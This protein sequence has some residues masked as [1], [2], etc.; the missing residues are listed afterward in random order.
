VPVL[1]F[2]GFLAVYLL[3][4]PGR[5]SSTDPWTRYA[6][7]VGLVEYGRPALPAPL[8][9]GAHWVV[10]G[11]DGAAYSYFGIGQSLVFAP[12]YWLGRS[13]RDLTGNEASDWPAVVA[14]FANTLV[15]AALAVAV[16]G[17][18]RQLGHSGRVALGAAALCGFGTTVWDA[19]REN[20]DH[21]IEAAALATSLAALAFGLRRGSRAAVLAAGGAFGGGLLTRL[22]A[23]FGL[24]GA[25]LLLATGLGVSRTRRERV[26]DAGWFAAGVMP[27]AVF[28]LWYNALRFGSPF[29]TGYESKPLHW[30][31]TPLHRGIATLLISPGSGFL[32]YVPLTLAVPF[33]VPWLYRRAPR[34]CQ[35]LG[36]IALGYVLGYGQF[37]GLGLWPWNWGPRYLVPLMPLVAVTWAEA[38]ARWTALARARRLALGTLIAVSVTVQGLAA[39]ASPLRTG[40][41]AMV[42]GVGDARDGTWRPVWSPLTLQGSHVLNAV[43]HLRSGTALESP[44]EPVPAEQRLAR[45]LGLNSVDWWWVRA[46]HRGASRLW[47][48]APVAL[49]ALALTSLGGVWWLTAE[50][51]QPPAGDRPAT[52]A[53]HRDIE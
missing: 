36:V 43:R 48:L 13:I 6:V 21:L 8:H 50:R 11:R 14:S 27:A 46:L 47:L 32:W 4:A 22:S 3:T 24:P 16:F 2:V 37:Q 51:T 17:L 18:A 52:G 1:V 26:R 15:G 10:P 31:G 29:A 28:V 34:F 23:V 33:M 41:L 40:V 25:L 53:R 39:T 38:L 12:L 49:G 30:L 20:H 42:A 35:G 45:D 44:A 9:P 7:A 5:I 19:T